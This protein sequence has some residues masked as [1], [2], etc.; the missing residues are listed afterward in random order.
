[1]ASAHQ[2]SAII[3][4]ENGAYDKGIGTQLTKEKLELA[5]YAKSFQYSTATKVVKLVPVLYYS[6]RCV[7]IVLKYA[8]YIRDRNA[9]VNKGLDEDDVERDSSSWARL[10]FVRC[11]FII[12]FKD[13]FN[14]LLFR[15]T[16]CVS[17]LE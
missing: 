12:V 7:G 14:F 16:L 6:S 5:T 3:L 17:F 4:N 15:T 1:M 13:S 9:I 8:R 2:T 10:A 11:V